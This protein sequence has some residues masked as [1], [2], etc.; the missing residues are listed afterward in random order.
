MAITNEEMIAATARL[1]R[2]SFTVVDVRAIDGQLMRLRF[3]IPAEAGTFAIHLPLPSAPQLK[4]WLCTIPDNADHAAA[5]LADFITEEVDTGCADWAATDA[6]DGDRVFTLEPYGFH[7]TDQTRHRQL[8]R[9]AGPTGWWGWIQEDDDPDAT[10]GGREHAR[11]AALPLTYAE[12][13]AS[14]GDLPA[15]YRHIT[16]E[17]ILG[18]GRDGFETAVERLM[19]WDMHRRAGL[20]VDHT[21]PI[22]TV[23]QVAVI[24][25]LL[26]GQLPIGAPVRVVAVMDE[27]TVHGFA[28]GTLPGHPESGEERFLIHHNTDDTVRAT[29][30]AFSRPAR[31]YTK[32]GAPLAR[33]IQDQTTN[34]YL[35]ALAATP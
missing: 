11:L 24:S 13:G 31:W 14:A 8:T 33:H 28:Y 5:M 15:G 26:F 12:V 29:I 25:I 30:R 9:S 17:R 7:P 23:G 6:E 4:P 2:E 3:S 10:P 27:P 34:R 18:T 22:V 20:L 35:D 16:V 32:L 1:Q 19:T 21:P